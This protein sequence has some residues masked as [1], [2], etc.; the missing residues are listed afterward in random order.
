MHRRI[1]FTLLFSLL[2]LFTAFAGLISAQSGLHIVSWQVDGL[3]LTAFYPEQGDPAARPLVLVAHGFAGSER[4]MRAFSLGLAHAGYTVIAWD[5][6]G[7]GANTE[8]DG[9]LVADAEKALAQAGQRGLGDPGRVAILGHSMGSGVALRFGQQRP[10]TAAVIA[11]SPVA[12]AVTPDLPHNLL[13][14]AGALEPAFLANAQARL[15]EA[16]GDP[17]GLVGDPALGT[18]RKLRIISN[19]EHLSILF[20]PAAHQAARDWLD[21]AFDPQADAQ[22]YTDLRLM[23]YLLGIGGA[24]LMGAALA[25]YIVEEDLSGFRANA[26]Y[27]PDRPAD[28]RPL[29]SRLLPLT[30]GALAAALLLTL[31]GRLGV[32]LNGLLGVLVGGYLLVWFGLAGM[33]A[34]AIDPALARLGGGAYKAATLTLPTPRELAGGLLAFGVLWLGFGLLGHYTWL[35]WLL[36]TPRLLLWLPGA[37][38]LLPWFLALGLAQQPAHGWGSLGWWLAHS[39]LLTGATLLSLLL[40]PELRF[41]TFILQLFPV[42]LALHALAAAPL[43]RAWPYALSAALFISWLLLAVFPQS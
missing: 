28:G 5:F 16:G 37:A 32:D 10:E 4:L 33:L 38:L 15:A 17:A 26:V 30:A 43:R 11:I 22:R 35:N 41:L 9:D 8:P 13:L 20:A 6:A 24:L 40:N 18:A 23:W 2:L 31:A 29:I 21:A 7:H 3:P 27:Q 25:R 42:I 39:L 1:P 14:M 19:V 36:S 12:Q 34:L